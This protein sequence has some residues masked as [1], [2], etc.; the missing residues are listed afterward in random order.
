MEMV[1]DILC[2]AGGIMV[3]AAMAMIWRPLG[4]LACGVALIVLGYACYAKGSKTKANTP[5]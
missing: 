2:F 1:S 5:K 3:V 4:L